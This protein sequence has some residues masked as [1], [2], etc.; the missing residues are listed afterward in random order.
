[1]NCQV[2]KRFSVSVRNILPRAVLFSYTIYI[3][4][5]YKGGMSSIRGV[6]RCLHKKPV[7][8]RDSLQH[9]AGCTYS[10][11]LYNS[12]AVAANIRPILIPLLGL[13]RFLILSEFFCLFYFFGLS[14]NIRLSDLLGILPPSPSL[15][16]CCVRFRIR[17]IMFYCNICITMM[18]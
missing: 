8:R 4:V 14:D 6:A 3:N 7:S 9:P 15:L 10:A 12:I 17:I 1:M 2:N 5:I 18:I 16:F 11:L 13:L